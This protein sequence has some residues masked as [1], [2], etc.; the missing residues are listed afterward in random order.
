VI[1]VARPVGQLGNRLFQ[2]AHFVALAADTGMTVANP[3][4]G[5]NAHY[6]PELADDALC[7]YPRPSRNLPVA[8]RGPAAR[9]ASAAMRATGAIPKVEAIEIPDSEEHD[10]EGPTFRSA[11]QRARIVLAAGWQLRA[12]RAFAAHRDE[13][14]RVFTPAP[15]HTE[16]ATAAVV[17]A[18]RDASVVVGVHRRRG[19]YARWQDGRYLYDDDQYAEV[20]RRTADLLGNE[21][22]FLVCSDEPVPPEAFDGLS[23]H[24]GP[25]KPVEDLHA[26]SRCDRLIGPPS[27]FGAWASFMGEVPRYEIAVPG[28]GFDEGAFRAFVDG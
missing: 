8:L 3:G 23:V 7:R 10:L 11:A 12:Y 21:V 20:M 15:Q 5:A 9:L 16:A 1:V 19:D 13:I 14:R 25:G 2:Y 17:A 27:T 26:L 18:R 28:G 4:L 24:P 6:F 22:A